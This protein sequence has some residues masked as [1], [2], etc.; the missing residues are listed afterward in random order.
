MQAPLR[1]YAYFPS[2]FFIVTRSGEV[3]STTLRIFPLSS[4]IMTLNG[5]CER[6]SNGS[7][8]EIRVG[9]GGL[10]TSYLSYLLIW[11]TAALATNGLVLAISWSKK[12]ASITSIPPITTLPS[13]QDSSFFFVLGALFRIP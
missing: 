7:L 10:T 2:S 1:I 11:T 8:V 9:A 5:S 4:L 3:L 6:A 13:R 12:V